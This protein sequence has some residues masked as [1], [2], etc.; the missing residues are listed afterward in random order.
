MQRFALWQQNHSSYRVID[1]ALTS[2]HNATS[3]TEEQIHTTCTDMGIA[4]SSQFAH[5]LGHDPLFDRVSATEDMKSAYR[6]MAVED[7]HT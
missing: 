7:G 5:I 6:Q 1:N 3:F 2:G 4:I